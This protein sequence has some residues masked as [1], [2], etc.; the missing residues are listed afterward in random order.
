MSSS[1]L[2]TP[3]SATGSLEHGGEGHNESKEVS[4][5]STGSNRSGTESSETKSVDMCIIWI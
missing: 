4:M 3:S 5:E 1:G 2:P